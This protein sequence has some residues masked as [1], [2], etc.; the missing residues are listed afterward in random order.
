MNLNNIIAAAAFSSI[1]AAQSFAASLSAEDYCSPKLAAPK[2][3]KDMHPLKDGESFSA[4]SDD[5]RSIDVYSYKTGEK[6]STLFSLD[7]VK[8]DIKI[9]DF[10]GYEL[11][12]NE[13]KILI[14]NNSKKI[15]RNSFTAD[16]Y[17]YDTFRSTLARIS[18]GGSQRCAT[19]SHDGRMVA[20]VRDNNVFIS[21]ID[22][23]TDKA[24]TSDGKVNSI[25]Y[26]APDWAYEEEFGMLNSLR[27]SSDDNTLAFIR[28]DESEVPVYSF[29]EYGYY[30]KEDVLG[31][32]YP[33][34]FRYKYPL[35]GYPNS[36]VEVRAY[37]VD[38]GTTK[39]MGLDTDGK[40]VP[41]IDFAGNGS[42]LMVMVVNR[43]QNELQLFRVNP[44]STVAHPV[45]TETSDAWLS[46]DAYQMVR[47]Y[48]SSF[49]IASE[50][51]GYRHLYEYD[52]SGNKLRQLTSGNWNVTDYYG[53]D[54]K[55]GTHFI[56]T[57]S[58][59]AIN[60][61]VASVDSKGNVR[62][63]NDM[64]GTESAS[65]SSNFN[66][67]L[68]SYSSAVTPPQ[69]TICTRSGKLVKEM[70]MNREYASRYAAAP[71]MEFLKVANAEGEEMNAYMIKPA[72]FDASNKYPL[73]MY[74]YNGPDSQL[75][76]NA[77]RMDGTYYLAAEGFVV[78]AVDGRGT[79]NRSRQ[80]AN[81]VYKQLGKYET[82]D[83]L[84]GAAYFSSLPFVDASRTACFGWSYGGYMTL[85]ELSDPS[86]RFKA[87][88]SMAPV[89]DW[90]FYDSV[91][92]E[93]YMQ[94]PQQ[95]ERGYK[96]ASAIERS[97]YLRGRLLIMSGTSDDNVHFYNTL[98]YTSKLNAEGQIF[99]MM[100]YSG[101]EHSLRMGNAREQLY[102]KVVDFLKTQ[103]TK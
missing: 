54:S 98:R 67:F 50:R 100:A 101:F 12:A 61:N 91:Y 14:W 78:C 69:Y 64:E 75:V 9:S 71:K 87:G 21:N 40:Y 56:Q 11:S 89:T 83:Q 24:I 95:N 38:N 27:W 23:K 28:F 97:G 99:D 84:A 90:R 46:P 8:G 52:Y 5:G 62:L 77:W 57:T 73:L 70:Q 6:I 45:I 76:L 26:G 55:N 103:L 35:A 49:V 93:R 10:E 33:D 42:D 65:F 81:V 16:Y 82:A 7:G 66:Y 31:P 37:N 74:Q 41:A 44:G 92:T 25:I 68:R 30:T 29:D 80:W 79:G 13:K 96:L 51:S 102:K 43:N 53:F 18:E 59:G 88:V 36:K 48:Q 72:G 3:V 86:C 22:Y 47:Y 39:T 85:M 32:M 1:V 20:Y 19:I 63:L 15:Y 17:V 94:T 60:R 4:V 2:G 34:S 58:K